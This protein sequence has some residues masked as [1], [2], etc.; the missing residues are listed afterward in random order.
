MAE[1]VNAYCSKATVRSDFTRSGKKKSV[2]IICE[3]ELSLQRMRTRQPL[4]IEFTIKSNNITRQVGK[5]LP[6]LEVP[7]VIFSVTIQL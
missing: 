4:W 6:Y 5:A 7:Q 3:T 1:F 2:V